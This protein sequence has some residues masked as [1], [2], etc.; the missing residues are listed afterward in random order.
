M[1]LRL[2]S[3]LV[4]YF[5]TIWGFYKSVILYS[6]SP[7]AFLSAPYIDPNAAPLATPCKAPTAPT[8]APLDN[9]PFTPLP[10][11]NPAANP[12]DPN[13]PPPILAPFLIPS[14]IF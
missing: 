10:D 12:S 4:S 11:A 3:T 6:L 8:M 1:I 14:T 9:L 7:L 2:S 5:N 13:V